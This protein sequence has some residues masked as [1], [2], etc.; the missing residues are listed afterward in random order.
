MEVH[1]LGS[2]V[3][4]DNVEENIGHILVKAAYSFPLQ[5]EL[6]VLRDCHFY[7][8]QRHTMYPLSPPTTGK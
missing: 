6:F 2:L 1:S 7:L 3:F 4:L 8:K 5:C